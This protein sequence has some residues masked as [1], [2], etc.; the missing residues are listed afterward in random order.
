VELP[1]I[2]IYDP[3]M[4]RRVTWTEDCRV[5]D[6]HQCEHIGFTGTVGLLGR[7]NF[8]TLCPCACH[9]GCPADRVELSDAKFVCTCGSNGRERQRDFEA[10][11][12][13]SVLHRIVSRRR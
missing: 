5:H 6:H 1:A 2:R 13:P 3:P 7:R 12:K 9:W 11:S 8:V 10:M 4:E